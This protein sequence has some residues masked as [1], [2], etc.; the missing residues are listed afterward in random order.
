MLIIIA[1]LQKSKQLAIGYNMPF[2]DCEGE[3][4]NSGLSTLAGQEMGAPV[5]GA[6]VSLRIVKPK[7]VKAYFDNLI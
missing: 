2:E 4:V 6:E 1:A 3:S 5:D 7:S